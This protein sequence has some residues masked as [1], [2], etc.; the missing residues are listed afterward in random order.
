MV[1]LYYIIS[2]MR[3]KT[4]QLSVPVYAEEIRERRKDFS[5]FLN[6]NACP[7]SLDSRRSLSRIE[8]PAR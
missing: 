8:E 7:L 6:V 1:S 2:S 4:V 3:L 5:S